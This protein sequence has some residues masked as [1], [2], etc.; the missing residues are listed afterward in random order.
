MVLLQA[1]DSNGPSLQQQDPYPTIIKQAY[2]GTV[3]CDVCSLSAQWEDCNNRDVDP[4]HVE[5]L[6]AHF[7]AAGIHR[8]A[9]EHRMKATVKKTEW[10]QL[11]A[12]IG[13][14][15]L[16]R[17]S[18]QSPSQPSGGPLRE[19]VKDP[20]QM[21]VAPR[22]LPVTPILEAGQHRQHALVELLEEQESIAQSAEGKAS[23]TKP[24]TDDVC[25]FFFFFFF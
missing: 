7:K 24:P 20:T 14:N 3:L 8:T 16:C 13:D 19:I 25:F 5:K 18:H 22:D 9:E 6:K 1:L 10:P 21:L 2:V 11:L 12:V 15:R 23:G 4:D 17:D